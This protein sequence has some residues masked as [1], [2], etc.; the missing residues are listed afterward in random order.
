MNLEDAAAT[1]RPIS[2]KALKRMVDDGL[3]SEPLN[4]SDQSSLSILCR[5]WSSEWYVAQM[6]K[7]FKPD[8]RAL[9]L[10]FPEFGKIDRYILNS[11]LNLKPRISVSIKEMSN[12]IRKFYHIEYPGLKIKHVRQIAYNLRRNSRGKTRRQLIA[13]LA[14]EHESE[15]NDLK[16]LSKNPNNKLF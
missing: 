8:K 9:M 11:F 4:E 2:P 3:I 13:L 16:H 15:K 7:T 6:N 1:F 12:R 14:L 10:A 5:I